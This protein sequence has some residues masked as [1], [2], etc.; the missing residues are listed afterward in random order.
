LKGVADAAKAIGDRGGEIGGAGDGT[1]GD[2]GRDKRVL[3]E[4]LP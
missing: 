3:D 1:Q 4:I 2:H